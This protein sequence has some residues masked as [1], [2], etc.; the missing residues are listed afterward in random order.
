[1]RIFFLSAGDDVFLPRFYNKVFAESKY[2]ICGVAR[3]DDPHF[4]KFLLASFKFMGWRLFFGEVF[5]QVILKIKN[6]F[7]KIFMSSKVTSIESICRKYNVEFLSI[8]K[9]NTKAFRN[10]L[11]TKQIDVLVSVACPQILK[12]KILEIPARAAINVHYALLPQY[13]GQYPSFWVLAK[14]EEYTGVSVHYMAEKIDAGEILV[15]IKEKIKTDD[16]FYSLVGRLKTTIGPKALLK[17]LDK[18]ADSDMTGLPNDIDSGSYFSF[19]TRQDM[20]GFLRRGRRW[21]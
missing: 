14:G 12:K 4:R 10:F 3:V 13:R 1:M 11:Q 2:D 7:Y 16:T 18:I 15:Q 8:P 19:P 21:R 5:H 6:I 20:I 9:I 17:A